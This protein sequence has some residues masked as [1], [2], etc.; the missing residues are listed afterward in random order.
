MS[1]MERKNLTDRYIRSL[2]PTE[3]GEVL[4]VVVPGLVLRVSP[5]SKSFALIARYPGSNNPTRRSL[6]KYG[7]ITLQDVRIKARKWLEL[8]E[9]GRDPAVEVE[10]ERLAEARKRADSFAQVVKDFAEQ[11]LAKER[12]GYDAGRSLQ[13]FVKAWGNRPIA[14]LDKRDIRAVIDPIAVRAPYAAHNALAVIR[15]FFSWAVD[16]DILEVSPCAMLKAS[17]IIG[18]RKPRQRVLSEDELVALHQAACSLPFP[19]GPLLRMLLLGGQRHSDCAH[20][21]WSEI[22][23]ERRE[24]IIPAGRFKSEVSHLVPLSGALVELLSSLPRIKGHDRLFPLSRGIVD[25]AKSRLDAR[26]L[27]ILRE[28]NPGAKLEPF[29]IHDIRRSCRTYLSKLRIQTE[30]AEAVIGHG[31]RGLE[32]HYNLYEYADEKRHAL[33][34]WASWLR[35]LTSPPAANV[36]SLSAR[37]GATP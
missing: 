1:K 28:R 15:R 14:D 2:A 9:R 31:K 26:M 23:L 33:E 19:H 32:R 17:A 27:E 16:R 34:L 20:A 7:A 13:Y 12:Q 24:W 25:E 11:K 8:I 5:T 35:N 37:Q 22:S 30:V 4:D 36:V 29:V 10:R 21:A 18:K 6:G 3:R